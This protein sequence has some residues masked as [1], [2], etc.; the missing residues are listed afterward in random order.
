MR[1]RNAKAD[2]AKQ[3]DANR[4]AHGLSSAQRIAAK[5]TRDRQTKALDNH[6]LDKS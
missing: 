1:K 3:A 6:I 2:A 4:I 5:T